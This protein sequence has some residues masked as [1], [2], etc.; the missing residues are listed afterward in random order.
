MASSVANRLPASPPPPLLEQVEHIVREDLAPMVVAIDRRGVYPEGVLRRLGQ[1]GAFRQHLPSQNDGRRD[2]ASAIQAME[3]AGRHCLS[4][5]FCMW[6]Q[7]ALGWYLENADYRPVRQEA[8]AAVA[9]GELLGGTALSNPMKAFAGIETLR[10]RVRPVPGGYRANGAL[11]WVSN[12]GPGHRFAG[13]FGIEG[14]DRTVMALID[15]D[16]PGFR[17]Q[18]CAEF[19]ALEGTRTFACHFEDAFIPH[20]RVIADAVPPYMQR[21]KAGFVLLQMGM[22]LG[23]IEGCLDILRDTAR[24]HGHVNRYLDEQPAAL[25]EDL[26]DARAATYQLASEIGD[27]SQSFFADVLQLRLTGSELALKAANAAMLHAGARGYLAEAPAQR[28]LREAYF[29]AI[30]TPAIKHLR[31]ELAALRAA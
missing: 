1:A 11:P 7:N 22:G 13:I 21:I 15:C 8:L 5:A 23:L 17:L 4:T 27:C 14:S 9:A 2:F 19:T 29:V 16:Q 18:R 28:R 3:R 31:K 24:T 20:E 12:L 6:C 10:V 25:A 30:V 26:Q